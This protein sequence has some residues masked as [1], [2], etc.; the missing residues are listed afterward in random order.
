MFYN[1]IELY[2]NEVLPFYRSLPDEDK[3]N[4]LA[5]STFQHF[6]AYELIQNNSKMCAG[7][8]IVLDGQLRSFMHSFTGKE[9]TLFRLLSRDICI[10]S[11]SCIFKNL[12]YEIN[13]E[14]EKDSSVIILDGNGLKNISDSN[15]SIQKYLFELS[16]NKLSDILWTFDQALFSSLESRVANFLIDQ[17]NLDESD[18]LNLTHNKIAN[19]LGT[20]REVV[21]RTLK[22]F[23]I[24]GL[25]K[26]S[27]SS[28][29]ILDSNKLKDI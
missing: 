19:H 5:I 18:I 28:V 29:E 16:Q 12:N 8:I 7:L 10:L 3:N 11:A 24:N 21:S 25:I 14:A 13:I 9:I 23:E 27:R 20:A 17:S 6:K 1:K 2:L 15:I 4:I 22:K 26:L